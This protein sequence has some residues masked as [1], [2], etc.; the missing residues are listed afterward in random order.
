M[1]KF[2]IFLI[3]LL[4]LLLA[5]GWFISTGYYSSGERAGTISKFSER[6]YIFKTFEGQL[7]EGGYSGETGSLSPR[8]WDFSSTND[9]VVNKI[10][11]ALAT[12]ERV[13]LLYQ[14]KFMKFPWNGDT[15][16]II[17]DLRFLPKLEPIEAPKENFPA[18]QPPQEEVSS[19]V[20]TSAGVNQSI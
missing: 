6:G 1:G 10:R 18:S 14:E 11:E 9:S 12:G 15:K 7:M 8:Y 16:Y 17:T 3:I 5:V 4:V 20:D 13:T 19:P 2:K